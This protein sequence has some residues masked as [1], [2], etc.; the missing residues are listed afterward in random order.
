M[1]E[2]A[3]DFLSL[4]CMQEQ[5]HI[6]R[7]HLLDIGFVANYSILTKHEESTEEEANIT[8]GSTNNATRVEVCTSEGNIDDYDVCHERDESDHGCRETTE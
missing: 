1:S 3:E 4:K 6:V 5:S 7:E 2:K 8:E